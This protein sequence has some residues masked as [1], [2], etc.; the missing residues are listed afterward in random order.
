MTLSLLLLPN[1]SCAT[2][3]PPEEMRRVKQPGSL[4]DLSLHSSI[5]SS[6]CLPSCRVQSAEKSPPHPHDVQIQTQLQ[7]GGEPYS[8]HSCVCQPGNAH[9]HAA[10]MMAFT[11]TNQPA[12]KFFFFGFLIWF[13][14]GFLL[15]SIS[16]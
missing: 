9:M 8:S 11:N 1:Q 12:L 3:A 15:I 4:F 16:E 14:S 2:L 10:V 7:P 5:L 6:L 13:L